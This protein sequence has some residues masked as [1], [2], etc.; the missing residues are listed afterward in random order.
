MQWLYFSLYLCQRLS[1]HQARGCILDSLLDKEMPVV[2]HFYLWNTPARALAYS[3]QLPTTIHFVV[4]FPLFLR[5]HRTD[6]WYVSRV[7]EKAPFA[8]SPSPPHIFTQ[9][10][11]NDSG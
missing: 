4:T 9:A 2:Q 11:H 8:L 7:K 3:C 6:T 5:K 10:S 1:H